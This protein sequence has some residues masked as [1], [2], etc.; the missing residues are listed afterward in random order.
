MKVSILVPIYGVEKYIER[1]AVSLFEQTYEDI[2]YIFVN[3]C[4]KDNSIAIL[5]E[6][7]ERY[8]ARKP[9]VCIIEHEQNKGLGGA[10]NT[11]VAAAT[12]AFLMHVD[13][14]DYIDV[15]C[16]EKCVKKQIELE[17]DIVCFDAIRIWPKFTEI[18]HFHT[19]EN[20]VN[21]LHNML[22]FSAPS[23]IWCRFI[24]TTLYKDH[25]IIVEGGCNM[26]EDLQVTPRLY[27]Y[28]KKVAS[29][30]EALYYYDST[31][32][33]AYSFA[34]SRK[35]ADET[36]TAFEVLHNFFLDKGASYKQDLSILEMR[37]AANF[38]VNSLKSS[39]IEKEYYILMRDRIDSINKDVR[40][41]VDM[42]TRIALCINN[43]C[44]CC[45]YV[46][47]AAFIKQ[48]I[49]KFSKSSMTMVSRK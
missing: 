32:E 38:L 45:A 46:R 37:K 17:A 34:F 7:I 24:R 1:C 20:R 41:F 4:T 3:D 43:F 27:Y 44:L 29:I 22:S 33:S 39:P 12:G 6:V 26:G 36:W 40:S 21:L 48:I 49:K 16:V 13:S 47:M 2:E 31:N 8:P 9:Q 19:N 5:K 25:N 35:K 11:A 10:R 30:D 42:P 28:A 15:T 18:L 14:D 23:N